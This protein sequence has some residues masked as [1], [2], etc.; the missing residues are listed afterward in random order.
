MKGEQKMPCT[1][2]E[3]KEWL[4]LCNDEDIVLISY[5]CGDDYYNYY[6]T[7]DIIDFNE[8]NQL[9]LKISE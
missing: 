3:L 6:G 2:K 4:N 5:T 1:V 7:I 8:D 9:I